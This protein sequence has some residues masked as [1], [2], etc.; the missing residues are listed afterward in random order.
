MPV[1]KVTD[2]NG[3]VGYQWGQTGKVYPTRE[4]AERQGA[5]I[6]YSQERQG[7]KDEGVLTQKQRKGKK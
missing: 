3:K 6:R 1:R 2:K 4:Q 5:A 7:G